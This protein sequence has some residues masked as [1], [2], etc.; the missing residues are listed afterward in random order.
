MIFPALTEAAERGELILTQDGMC[1]WHLRRDG[2]VVIR[3]LL[4]LPP[5]RG[6]G[7]GR[8][9]LGE[10]LRRNPGR[11]VRARC[12]AAYPS[13]GFWA[14]MGFTLTGVEGAVNVWEL[15]PSS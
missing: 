6:V 3:E 11:V 13:N 10:V 7:I 2:V 8:R 12:P 9:M 1:R 4:V 5:W 14:R 15:R